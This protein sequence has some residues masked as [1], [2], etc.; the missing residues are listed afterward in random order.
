MTGTDQRWYAAHLISPPKDYWFLTQNF[1]TKFWLIPKS[2]CRVTI[3]RRVWPLTL[4]CIAKMASYRL[5]V[6]S[7][8]DRLITLYMHPKFQLNQMIGS[9]DTKQREIWPLTIICIAKMAPY[10]FDVIMWYDRLITINVHTKLQLDRISGSPDTKQRDIWTLN[11]ICI[12]KSLISIW[13]Y[14]K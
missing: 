10:Q 2:C 14:E 5:G 8:Y 7:W 6:I 3:Q 4:I 9:W 1:D 11:F 13:R 12:S